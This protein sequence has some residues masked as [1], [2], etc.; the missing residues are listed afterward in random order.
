MKWGACFSS[1]HYS[2][3]VYCWVFLLSPSWSNQIG[4]T[5]WAW[6]SHPIRV[7]ETLALRLVTGEARPWPMIRDSQRSILH[8]FIFPNKVAVSVILLILSSP[9]KTNDGSCEC[10]LNF[11]EKRLHITSKGIL[12]HCS[13]L[14]RQVRG[15]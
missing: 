2:S 11:A 15:I 5:S 8:I 9:R 10:F 4:R 14:T 1:R 6:A 3:V 7:G 12:L 13:R